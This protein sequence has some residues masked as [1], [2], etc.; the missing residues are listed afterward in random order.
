MT[1]SRL[2]FPYTTRG[3]AEL[4]RYK[5]IAISVGSL[6]NCQGANGNINEVEQATKVSDLL[7]DKLRERGVEV[8]GAFHE[9][10]STDK[11]SASTESVTGTMTSRANSIYQCISM[12]AGN[13]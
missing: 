7:A 9:L 8:A 10:T 1:K 13:Q 12:P 2:S 4:P 5:S 11:N 6:R 3:E